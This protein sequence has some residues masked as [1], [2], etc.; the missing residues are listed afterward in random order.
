MGGDTLNAAQEDEWVEMVLSYVYYARF[1]RGI[2]FHKLAPF[3]ESDWN[4]RRA[5]WPAPRR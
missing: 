2:E 1:N 4:G 5:S 3:N